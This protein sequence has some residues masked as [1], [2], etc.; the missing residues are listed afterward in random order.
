M[1]RFHFFSSLILS[2]ALLSGCS[3]SNDNAPFKQGPTGGTVSGTVS[4]ENF[5]V[6]ADSINP[7]VI[8]GTTFNFT[9]TDDNLTVYIGDR[10]NHALGD[11]HTIYFKSEYGLLKPDSCI[12]QDG[13]C[14]ITWSA[15]AYPPDSVIADG[16][17][18]V[19]AYTQGE[20]S[21]VDTNGNG[22][23]DN[24]ES[25]TD[26]EEPYVDTD[27]SPTTGRF[28]NTG[29]LIID[30]PSANDPTGK[31][32]VHDLG[33]GLFNGAGC[34]H[35]SLCSSR[36]TTTIFTR[37]YLDIIANRVAKYNLGVIV[38]GLTAT[39]GLVLQNNYKDDLAIGGNGSFL[40]ST[41]VSDGDP[42][43][44]TVLSSPTNE[45]CFTTIGSIGVI[46][47]ADVVDIPIT[48][49]PTY[50]VGGTLTG[51]G[52]IA[53]G[54]LTLRLTGG[55]GG[56][57]TISFDST[58]PAF[59]VNFTFN[60]KFIDGAS[61]DVTIDSNTTGLDCTTTPIANPSGTIASADV[62]NVTVTCN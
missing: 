11:A 27:L 35:S 44:V 10:F 34:T 9:Q 55:V 21:F 7:S 54:V 5:S 52:T 40:F 2:L 29:D 51:T 8:D 17:V 30:V 38:T 26:Q 1:C 37:I 24:G 36:T 3:D 32:G 50:T 4:Q 59:P 12:T 19:T 16:Y 62:T 47:G 41:V 25:F 31:N 28:F 60:E 14:S 20:E 56:G 13:T 18:T 48:C 39:T 46:S 61:Y 6:L 49:V 57:D 22:T 43:D 45:L 53:S 23:F 33:D 58:T 42:Y 15:T